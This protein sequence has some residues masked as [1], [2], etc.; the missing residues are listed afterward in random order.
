VSRQY[1]VSPLPPFGIADGA[2]YGTSVTLTEVS[3]TPQ[4]ILPAGI[5]ELGTRLE[6]YAFGRFSNTVTPTLTFGLYSGTIAQAIGS[7]AV[8]CAS[9]AVTTITAATN[10]TWRIEGHVQIRAIG[11]SGSAL[12]LGEITNLSTGLT[13]MMPASAPTAVTVDT[14][15]ARYISLGATWG[16]SSASNT[17]TCHYFGVR[18]VN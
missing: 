14:T 10:R 12:G 1:W 4:I 16:T 2:A 3:P 11:T 15:V 13:D 5:L 8:L 18:L 6:W 7:A 9:S 17:L